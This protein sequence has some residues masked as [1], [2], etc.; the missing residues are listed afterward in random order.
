MN[1]FEKRKA[2]KMKENKGQ[3]IYGYARVSTSKQKLERQITNILKYNSNAVIY[4][5]KYTGKTIERKELQRLL[6]IVKKGDSIIFDSV[7]RMS[8]N[9][10]EGFALYKELYEKGVNLIFLN[11]SYINTSVYRQSIE[12]MQKSF[13][14]TTN[15]QDNATN[16]LV[17]SIM[18][19]IENY[20][21]ELLEKQIQ[22]AF[23]QSE[24]EL[25]DIHVRISQGIRERKAKGLATGGSA[26]RLNKKKEE[27][28]AYIRKN[29]RIFGGALTDKQIE[30][31]LS[32]SN[33]T[34]WKYKQEI[35]LQLQL[36]NE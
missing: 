23:S 18:Q 34:L 19:A 9:S 11:E 24:K 25:N 22:E 13:D 1:L 30:K 12:N 27:R 33:K 20:T 26:K 31:L 32:I 2:L 10:Q 16:K 17:S 8:R 14:I 6:S 36:S 29:S 35:K 4:Q 28:I 21:L 15:I 3:A 5:E 7:S